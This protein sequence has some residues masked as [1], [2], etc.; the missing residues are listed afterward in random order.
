MKGGVSR[1]QISAKNSGASRGGISWPS[2]VVRGSARTMSSW[3]SIAI[4]SI[5]ARTSSASSD[6]MDSQSSSSPSSPR[7]PTSS[8]SSSSNWASSSSEISPA[9]S[10]R[11]YSCASS[12]SS[13]WFSAHV[14][15]LCAF[16][17]DLGSCSGRFRWDVPVTLPDPFLPAAACCMTRSKSSLPTTGRPATLRLRLYRCQSER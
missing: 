4:F 14:S 15:N 16:C 11:A 17:T 3:S 10:L 6:A 13:W 1:V 12:I 7:A 5:R 2:W 8:R 9:A